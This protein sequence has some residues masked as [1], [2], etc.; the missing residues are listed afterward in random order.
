MGRNQNYKNVI[1]RNRKD[2]ESSE[3]VGTNY[4]RPSQRSTAVFLS[5]EFSL[6]DTCGPFQVCSLQFAT[7][8]HLELSK[9]KNIFS[10]KLRALSF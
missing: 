4:C 8:N 7:E 5:K 10:G 9:A 3:E 1:S 2:T 6:K